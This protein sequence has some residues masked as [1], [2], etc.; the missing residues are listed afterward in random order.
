[1]IRIELIL[2]IASLNFEKSNIISL[3]IL[4][5]TLSSSG[6]DSSY[7]SGC[8]KSFLLGNFTQNKIPKL[9]YSKYNV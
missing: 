3:Y 7:K 5:F 6:L 4:F 8:N 1:M 2:S 9:H